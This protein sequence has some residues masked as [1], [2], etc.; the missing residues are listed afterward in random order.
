MNQRN[1]NS[2]HI[3]LSW[4]GFSFPITSSSESSEWLDLFE[5]MRKSQ[6]LLSTWSYHKAYKCIT[7]IKE[8]QLSSESLINRGKLTYQYLQYS[9]VVTLV[10]TILQATGKRQKYRWMKQC[11]MLEMWTLDGKEFQ[12][13]LLYS[14]YHPDS[15]L[16]SLVPSFPI[17]KTDKWYLA[18]VFLGGQ[19]GS[20]P[21]ILLPQGYDK[22]RASE[23]ERKRDNIHL[24][25]GEGHSYR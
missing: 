15:Y 5:Q 11:V 1:K 2:R 9:I 24:E 19:K 25:R 14:L 23:Q 10:K 6:C 8:K 17:Y 22:L 12:F 18:S 13:W 21:E 3:H 7:W 4:K 20:F 16:N